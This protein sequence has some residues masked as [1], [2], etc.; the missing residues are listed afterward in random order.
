MIEKCCHDAV[1]SGI[2]AG[3]GTAVASWIAIIA[4]VTAE[5]TSV[6]HNSASE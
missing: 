4:L 2:A 5:D 3:D 1:K 6:L